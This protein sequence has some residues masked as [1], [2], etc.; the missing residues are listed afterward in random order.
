MRRSALR[1]EALDER[2]VRASPMDARDARPRGSRTERF[3]WSLPSLASAA[4][5]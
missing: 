1:D 4:A 2:L 5:A 3:V